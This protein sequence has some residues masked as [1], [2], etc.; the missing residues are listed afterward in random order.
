[1]VFGAVYLNLMIM[2]KKKKDKEEKDGVDWPH[3]FLKKNHD[4]IWLYQK[5]FLTLQY[6]T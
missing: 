3:L 5:F 2:D 1:M 4:F 6:Q